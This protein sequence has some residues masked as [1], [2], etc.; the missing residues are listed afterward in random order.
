[1]QGTGHLRQVEDK[2]YQDNG[3]DAFV[4]KWEC[5]TES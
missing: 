2:S 5:T 4:K 3:T 1:M